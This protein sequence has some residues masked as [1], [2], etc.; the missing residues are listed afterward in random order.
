LWAARET[1]ADTVAPELVPEMFERL[2]TRKTGLSILVIG[3]ATFALLSRDHESGD[4][5]VQF[6]EVRNDGKGVPIKKPIPKV[7]ANSQVPII[8]LLGGMGEVSINTILESDAL[9]SVAQI[10]HR[11][12]HDTLEE[13]AKR[14]NPGG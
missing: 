6:S 7:K 3:D 13:N 8:S 9:G 4:H 2:G 10:L 14:N 1:A 12:I 5:I 11:G